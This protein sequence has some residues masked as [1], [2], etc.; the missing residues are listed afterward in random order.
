MNDSTTNDLL[1]SELH[2][3]LKSLGGTQTNDLRTVWQTIRAIQC[4]H[5]PVELLS[6]I[7]SY[8]D[9][10]SDDEVLRLLKDWNETGKV[11]HERQ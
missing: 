6:I 11:I 5:P 4:W 2:A 8:G 7:G 1:V 10:L 3:A 9:T